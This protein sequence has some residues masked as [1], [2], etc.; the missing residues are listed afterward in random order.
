MKR[1]EKLPAGSV[2]SM[3]VYQNDEVEGGEKPA[4]YKSADVTSHGVSGPELRTIC[5]LLTGLTGLT[6]LYSAKS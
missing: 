3:V 4:R 2:Q 6:W 5:P 1:F